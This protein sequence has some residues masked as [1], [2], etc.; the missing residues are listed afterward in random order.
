MHIPYINLKAQWEDEKKRLLPIIESVM[1]GGV[2]VGGP[3]VNQ[4]ERNV[5]VAFGVKHCVALNSGTD[6]LIC[7]LYA[8][9]VSRGDEVITTPNSFIASTAA[10]VHLGAVPIFVDVLSD[11]NID[12][13]RIEAAITTKTKVIMPVHL[14]G[15]MAN[16]YAIDKIAKEY[17]LKVIEDCAQAIGSKL[18]DKYS[19]SFGDIGC[20]SCHPLKNLNACGD[21]GFLVTQDTDSAEKIKKFRNHGLVDRNNVKSFGTVSRMDELQAAILNFR[22][23]K[24]PS[25]IEK[26]RQHAKE[27]IDGLDSKN[28]FIPTERDGQFNSYH[29]FVIQT[30]P[31]DALQTFLKSENIETAIH[32]PIPIHLQ[33]AAARLGYKKGDFE[34]AERQAQQILTLPINQYLKEGSIKR[35]VSLIN[36]FCEG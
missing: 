25:V 17:N 3:Q 28:I 4:F 33:P 8:L 29:T 5:E 27:F 23:K 7:A 21:S 10:I 35:I 6:A 15:R 24:L 36:K 31:R 20:F 16:M 9:G 19:G 32:Y 26:R 18:H 13:S 1:A 2:F 14:T 34:V 22:I 30:E 12:D 11:Q